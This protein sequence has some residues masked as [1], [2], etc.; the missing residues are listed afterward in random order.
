MQSF[1][2]FARGFLDLLAYV[3]ARFSWVGEYLMRR[4]IH[5]ENQALLSRAKAKGQ[6]VYLNGRFH[7]SGVEHLELGENV[8]INDNAYFRAEGGLYIGD[9]AHLS[10]NLV[11]YTVN[12][13]YTGEALPYDNQMIKRSVRIDKNVW[14]G[15]NVCILPGVHIHEGAIIG[16]G[17]VVTKD[18]PK[19]AIVG[20]NP[21]RVLKYRDIEHYN[22]LEGSGRYAGINGVPIS[23]AQAAQCPSSLHE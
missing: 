21:A 5:F 19:C 4:K 13:E 18:V 8:H 1:R 17:A 6:H 22:Y 10:R 3:L 12:H 16:M 15:M 23:K 11:I 20:G 7:C 9:N 14:I 2:R